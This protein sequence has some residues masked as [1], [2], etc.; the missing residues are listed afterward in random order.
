MSSSSKYDVGGLIT[1]SCCHRSKIKRYK[2]RFISE[3]STILGELNNFISKLCDIRG[4]KFY[5]IVLYEIT[6]KIT[7]TDS[8][9]QFIFKAFA[10]VVYRFYSLERDKHL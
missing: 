9:Y 7:I 6:K 2:H 4:L 3:L 5:D 1:I 8:K 10:A